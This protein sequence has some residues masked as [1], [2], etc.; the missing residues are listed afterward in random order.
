MNN[1]TLRELQALARQAMATPATPEPKLAYFNHSGPCR[2]GFPCRACAVTLH[3][4]E[5]EARARMVAREST[6]RAFPDV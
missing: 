3:G 6:V 2:A 5:S 4:A 1:P